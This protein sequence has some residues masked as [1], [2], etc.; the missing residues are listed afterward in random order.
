VPPKNPDELA[1]AIETVL[2]NPR[3]G[4]RFGKAGYDRFIKQFTVDKMVEKYEKTYDEL[5]GL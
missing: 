4:E 2:D 5:L 3:L 1:R